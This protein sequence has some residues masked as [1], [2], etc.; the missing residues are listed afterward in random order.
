MGMLTAQPL[1]Y[2]DVTCHVLMHVEERGYARIVIV[3]EM[4][5]MVMR[6]VAL[7]VMQVVKAVVVRKVMTVQTAMRV[8]SYRAVVV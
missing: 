1:M 4:M 3:F 2:Y 6:T 5:A 7:L 8:K